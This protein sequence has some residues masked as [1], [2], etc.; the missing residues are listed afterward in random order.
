[1]I[2]VPYEAEHMARIRLQS[3]QICN[4]G[5]MEPQHAALLENERSFTI[6]DGDEVLFVGGVLHCWEGR[7]L[8]WCFLATDIGTRFTTVHRQVKRYF[9]L[10][11][12]PRV[13]TQVQLY[14]TAA[15]RW[16]RM[17]GFELEC[18][19]ARSFFPDGSDAALYAKVK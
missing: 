5:W 8:A 15:H 18:A 17:L 19:R 10:L 13:E 9:D 6:L 3:E 7:A 16:M 2:V 11:D 1:M 12:Y 14:F 4:I